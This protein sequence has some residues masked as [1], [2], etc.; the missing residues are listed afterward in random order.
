[1]RY[2]LFHN[3]SDDRFDGY[4]PGAA[5]WTEGIAYTVDAIPEQ[6]LDAVFHRHNMPSRPDGLVAPSLSVGDVIFDVDES[7]YWQWFAVADI[8]FMPIEPPANV[9]E[10]AGWREARELVSER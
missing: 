9:V 3:V 8:G 6:A 1:M 7:S 4:K 5:V 2:M 10:A